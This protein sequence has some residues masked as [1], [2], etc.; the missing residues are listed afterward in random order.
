MEGLSN[1]S[2]GSHRCQTQVIQRQRLL[3]RDPAVCFWLLGEQ[4]DWAGP[5]GRGGK[6]M[7]P[8]EFTGRVRGSD[9]LGQVTC[10]RYAG[11]KQQEFAQRLPGSL[12][13]YWGK[14]I[15]ATFL[16]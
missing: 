8:S 12:R 4:L 9:S 2:E 5:E 1:L 16:K 7:L 14:E 15:K 13:S 6:G 10:H 11:L 3:L